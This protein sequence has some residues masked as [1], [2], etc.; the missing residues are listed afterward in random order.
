LHESDMSRANAPQMKAT[1][2]AAL[3]GS[4][5]WRRPTTS[6]QE[7]GDGGKGLVDSLLFTTNP[8]LRGLKCTPRMRH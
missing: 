1:T 3:G 2:W 8:L 5:H 6:P 4:F 7:A